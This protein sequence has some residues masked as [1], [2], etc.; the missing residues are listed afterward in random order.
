M[1]VIK[2]KKISNDE[3][4]HEIDVTGRSEQAIDQ[5]TDGMMINLDH[6]NY[7]IDDTC[8]EEENRPLIK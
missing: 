6:A 3:V 5:I 8:I 4:V 1:K 7:W 2:V